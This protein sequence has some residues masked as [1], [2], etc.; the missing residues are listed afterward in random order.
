[1][2]LLFKLIRTVL[3]ISLILGLQSPTSALEKKSSLCR[4]LLV[5]I[6]Q[7]DSSGRKLFSQYSKLYAVARETNTQ[8]ANIDQ[9]RALLELLENNRSSF[10]RALESQK[11]FGKTELLNLRETLENINSDTG[12][13][14]SWLDA[15][16]GIPGRN[17]YL[18]YV[19]LPKYITTPQAF[20][21]CASKGAKFRELVCKIY[22]GKLRWISS[23]FPPESNR[24][25]TWPTGF[26]E[27]QVNL[28]EAKNRIIKY[29]DEN[30]KVFSASGEEAVEFMKRTSYPGLFDFNS[31]Q[32]LNKC[33]EYRDLQENARP[34]RVKYYVSTED[35]KPNPDFII[36]DGSQG[37]KILNTKFSGQVFLVPVRLE[38]NKGD[39]SDP[40]IAQIRRLAII[41]GD[42][43]RFSA[44]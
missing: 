33:R 30:S 9:T 34:I 17:F 43:Y 2:S 3:I 42:V 20:H 37:Q 15:Q 14:K 32:M 22:N 12:T 8:N 25:I 29:F 39:V 26:I 4:S 23:K 31:D 41:D 1:M 24:E 19:D 7:L 18:E 38:F 16:I 44:C 13:V 10:L 27:G 6:K 35:I 21:F 28:I 36:V 40:G 5:D 11:C